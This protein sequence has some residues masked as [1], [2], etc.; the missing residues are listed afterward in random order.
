MAKRT[1]ASGADKNEI[2]IG[3]DQGQQKQAMYLAQDTGH[4]SLVK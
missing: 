1:S 4:F 2:S 3:P